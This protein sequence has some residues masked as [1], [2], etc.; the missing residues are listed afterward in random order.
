M[1]RITQQSSPDAAKSYYTP[2]G[3]DYY[4]EGQEIIG[5]WGGEGAKRLGL[6]G[7]VEQRAFNALCENRHPR[8]GDQLTPRTKDARTVGYDFTWSVPKS[9]SLRYALTGDEALLD[10][11]RASVHET[12][13]D[14]EAEMKVRVRKAGRNEERTTGNMTYAEFIH[15]TSRPVDGVPDPHLHAHV[16]A[17]NCTWDH[18]EQEWKAGQFRDLKRDAPY[19][20]AAF[21]AR[22]ANRL[23]ALGY[24][25]ERKRDDFEL[26]GISAATLR[27][28]SRRTDKIEEEAKKRGIE[29]PDEKAQLGGLTRERKDKSLTWQE[30]R[31]KWDS[32]LTPEERAGITTMHGPPGASIVPAWRDAAAMDFAVRHEFAREA[33]VEEKKLLST[34][35]KQGL[36][37]VTVEGVR[38]EYGLQPL[39]VQEHQGRRV[40][41]TWQVL[42]EEEKLVDFARGGRGTCRP[43]APDRPI[44]RDWLNAGQRRAVE[45]VLRSRDRVMLVR[46]AAGTGKTT[47]MQEAVEAME[48]SG[49]RVVMLAPSA[50]A[51]RDVLREHFASADTVAMFLRNR[52]MQ[53]AAAGGVIWVDEASLLDSP[54]M[55]ALFDVAQ[56]QHARLVLMGDRRQH[57]SPSRGSPLRLLEEEAGVPS[58][59]VSEILRQQGDYKKAVH[60]LS[61]GK[62]EEGFDELDRL[63][64]VREVA[65]EER[66]LRLAEAYLTATAER[67]SDGSRKRALVVSPTH[68]EGDRI[69]AAIRQELA[70][71]GKLGEEHELAAFVPLHLTEA[72]RGEASSYLPGDMLQF[73]QNAKGF[74]SGT[75]LRVG[76]APLPLAQGARFQAY[77]ATTLKFAAGDRLRVTA[78][79]K[80]TDGR[81]R[82]NNGALFTIKEFT[83]EGH[84]VVDNGW[85]IGKDFGHVAHGYVVTSHAAQGKTVD[86]VLIGQSEASLPASD[87]QQLYVSVSR[88]KE[89]AII[90][91]DDKQAL[92]EAVRRSH[93]RLTATEVFRPMKKPGLKW[94]KGRLSFHRRCESLTLPVERP[95]IYLPHVQKEV[96]HE[97]E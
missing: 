83:R 81:H 27:K 2:S 9:V 12:M 89:Q 77:R 18:E 16:F 35:L 65:D 48:Q 82:L 62:T 32:W 74:R 88:G 58:V 40:A 95:G 33:V 50:A 38:R 96:V 86:K 52:E 44:Q 91:T 56:R 15:T 63:G 19:W 37:A 3:A 90:F 76:A 34:A 78:N 7:K 92:R 57:S 41:T 87:R 46:G 21:R 30:L 1:L 51:A 47:L 75:R 72:E 5:R 61:E 67:K 69:T 11:F 42:A 93:E 84:I 26:V 39:L 31:A 64:W 66:Y 70:A 94:L 22:L 36:G 6:D 80:T 14:I 60:L 13:R 53:A 55:R 29:D 97:R 20:Q 43:L 4:S 45:H 79:G 54:T 23:Q 25:I 49:H 24:A 28:F 85:V 59:E 17:F 8:T 73:H 71:Q 10:A 68:A